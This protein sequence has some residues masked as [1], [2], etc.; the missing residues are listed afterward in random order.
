MPRGAGG[1]GHDLVIGQDS[2][3]PGG[4][5]G[6]GVPSTMLE[7]IEAEGAYVAGLFL[8]GETLYGRSVPVPAAVT[9]DGFL[10]AV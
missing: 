2:F 4:V 5:Q 6:G 1:A 8:Q 7:A 10:G 3:E 9:G